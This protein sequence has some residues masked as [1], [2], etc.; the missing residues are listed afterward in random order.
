MG[1][2]YRVCL[3]NER[4]SKSKICS[5][6]KVEVQHRVSSAHSGYHKTKEIGVKITHLKKATVGGERQRSERRKEG[7]MRR[8]GTPESRNSTKAKGDNAKF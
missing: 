2:S 7:N 8:E 3:V 4:E 6:A 5:E 1:G